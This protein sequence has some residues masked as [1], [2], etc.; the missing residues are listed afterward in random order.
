MND[1][2]GRY[3][4]TF[5]FGNDFWVGSKTSCEELQNVKYNEVVPPFRV[6][7]SVAKLRIHL[8]QFSPKVSI[9]IELKKT[10][11]LT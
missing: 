6:H 2:S 5:F 7:F 9:A 11:C 1:A 4:G 3:G 8:D 10:K